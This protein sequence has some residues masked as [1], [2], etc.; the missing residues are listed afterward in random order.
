MCVP[1]PKALGRMYR[2]P[3]RGPQQDGGRGNDTYGQ[4]QQGM[5]QQGTQQGISDRD[6]RNVI[7][8]LQEQVKAHAATINEMREQM[9]SMLPKQEFYNFQSE[10]MA[11]MQN[12]QREQRVESL[13]VGGD[14][15]AAPAPARYVPPGPA[16]R[17]DDYD[18]SHQ[19]DDIASQLAMS[20][21]DDARPVVGQQQQNR[22]ANQ[23]TPQ[24]QSTTRAEEMRRRIQNAFE[25][26]AQKLRQA[27]DSSIDEKAWWREMLKLDDGLDLSSLQPA[28]DLPQFMR[29]MEKEGVIRWSRA[30]G[31]GLLPFPLPSMESF[32]LDESGG[33]RQG[34]GRGGGGGGAGRHHQQPNQQQQGEQYDRRGGTPCPSLSSA[35]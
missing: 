16:R 34:G 31:D 5:Q 28:Q 13:S 25:A 12:H 23:G 11:A 32:G 35:Y 7:G 21:L 18:D 10:V 15:G 24:F 30:T 3:G 33:R 19:G 8:A 20:V 22:S 2:P 29:A 1:Q 4:A 6:L 26:A 9:G 17:Q 27:P 14:Y